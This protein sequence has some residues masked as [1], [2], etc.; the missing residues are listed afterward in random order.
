MVLGVLADLRQ[1]FSAR[2]NTFEMSTL[3][4][5]YVNYSYNIINMNCI[6]FL[7]IRESVVILLL[8]TTNFCFFRK[9]KTR[10]GKKALE[11]RAPLVNENVK[12]A[13]FLRGPST[14]AVIVQCLKDLV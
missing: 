3:I 12:S 5:K 14:D 13:M 2:K 10:R 6:C 4:K 11:K 1:K 8:T 9:A 7:F